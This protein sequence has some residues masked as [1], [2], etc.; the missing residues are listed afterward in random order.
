MRNI[1]RKNKIHR[2]RSTVLGR[3]CKGNGM[4]Y[5]RP[6]DQYRDVHTLNGTICLHI[7]GPVV[8][9]NANSIKESCLRALWEHSMR[10]SKT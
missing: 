6:M 2:Q 10:F 1:L 7:D 4:A 9:V 5:Y 8:F 3:M